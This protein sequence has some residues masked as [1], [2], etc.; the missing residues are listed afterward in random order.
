[1]SIGR[2]EIFH[3]AA[4]ERHAHRRPVPGSD[5]SPRQESYWTE[6]IMVLAI[7]RTLGGY[8]VFGGRKH[9]FHIDMGILFG[10]IVTS[11]A[12]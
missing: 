4:S 11:P 6:G 1:M 2:E 12:R 5:C 10:V 9:L 7:K 8:L 3:T